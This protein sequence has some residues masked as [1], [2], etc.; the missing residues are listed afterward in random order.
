MRNAVI[1][2]RCVKVLACAA[3]VLIVPTGVVSAQPF[4]SKPIEFVVHT[5]PGGGTDVFARAV[6]EMLNREKLI[7]QPILVVNRVG[8]GGAIAFSHIK[9]KRGDPYNVLTVATGSLLS[10]AARTELGLGLEHYTLLAFF[11]MD[12][13]VISVAVDSKFKT[14]KELIDAGRREPNTMTMSVTTA[15]GV[16]RHLLYLLDKETGAK[17]KHVAFKSGADAV[18]AVAGGHVQFTA[19]NL[20]EMFGH[21]EAKKMR[22][23]AVT[24]E[25]RLSAV[26]DAP[27]LLELGFPSM[28]LGTGRGFAMPAGVPREA[29]AAM[30]ATLRKFHQTQTWKDFAARNMYEDKYLGSAEFT[31]YMNKRTGELREFLLAVGAVK[32]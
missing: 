2:R 8:G 17:F 11:A 23:L 25:K 26:P 10:A 27:T 30:E 22:V 6:G 15:L 3:F 1:F 16:S 32:P 18:T 5:S 24:G 28:V 21:I 14:F 13:Q 7:T 9:S 4:P 19:E 20:S 12:P 29:A 31:E